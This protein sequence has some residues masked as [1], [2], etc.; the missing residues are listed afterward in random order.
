MPAR[1]WVITTQAS[2]IFESGSAALD[3]I[4]SLNDRNLSKRREPS[5]SKL[6]DA[7][8]AGDG[9]SSSGLGIRGAELLTWRRQ[10]S[11][12][13]DIGIGITGCS[14]ISQC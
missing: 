7:G 6:E 5:G 3:V 13:P 11:G 10:Q 1:R 2:L 12:V 8:F 14:V 9:F 4:P